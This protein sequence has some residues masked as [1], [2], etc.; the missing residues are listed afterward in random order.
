MQRRRKFTKILFEKNYLLSDLLSRSVSM[1]SLL[2]LLESIIFKN[3]VK[4]TPNFTKQDYDRESLYVTFRR[5]VSIIRKVAKHS[6]NRNNDRHVDSV[7][8]IAPLSFHQMTSR[9]RFYRC[10]NTLINDM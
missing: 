9:G 7:R 3:R 1:K 8:A 5:K 2:E 10:K 6:Q 4:V